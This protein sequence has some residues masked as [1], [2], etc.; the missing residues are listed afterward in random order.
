M[1]RDI[2]L[3]SLP[4]QGVSFIQC[5]RQCGGE[6]LV[7]H[8]IKQV[9]QN[10]GKVIILN[11][12]KSLQH[13][14]ALLKKLGLNFSQN[15]ITYIDILS[16]LKE[17]EIGTTPDFQQFLHNLYV[18]I[19][20]ESN[21]ENCYFFCDSLSALHTFQIAYDFDVKYL[22]GFIE[23]IISLCHSSLQLQGI[24]FNSWNDVD[25]DN[26]WFDETRADVVAQFEVFDGQLQ[27]IDGK[28][29]CLFRNPNVKS[30]EGKQIYEV[31]GQNFSRVMLFQGYES[32]M[33]FVTQPTL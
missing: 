32:G 25:Q 12:V 5:S 17:M 24:V 2:I 23:S 1:D 10:S 22:Y 20:S 16:K 7:T 13:Y 3:R 28:V 4:V 31:V 11:V 29:S 6:F 26:E 8:L 21:G 19:Q 27:N 18:D 14:G 9:I 30:F 15:K 33:Q